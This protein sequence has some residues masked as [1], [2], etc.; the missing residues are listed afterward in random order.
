MAMLNFKAHSFQT[1]W[2]LLLGH[3]QVFL[4][5]KTINLTYIFHSFEEVVKAWEKLYSIQIQETWYQSKKL[6][7]QI[8]TFVK[9]IGNW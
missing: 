9:K 2:A 8:C 6:D 7:L 1:A 4:I 5:Y 3:H